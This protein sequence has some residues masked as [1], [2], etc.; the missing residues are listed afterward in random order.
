M[1][2]LRKTIAG[3]QLNIKFNECLFIH[4]PD[5]SGKIDEMF[6]DL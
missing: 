2:A 6:V 5:E 4:R 1:K 3:Y